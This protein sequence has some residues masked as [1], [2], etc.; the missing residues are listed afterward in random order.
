VSVVSSI[1]VTSNVT[2]D[3]SIMSVILEIDQ[4]TS[5]KRNFTMSLSS[6]PLYTYTYVTFE[7]GI[8]DVVVWAIDGNGNTA[9]LSGG[10][11]TVTPAPTNAGGGGGSQLPIIVIGNESVSNCNN[12]LKCEGS[13]GEDPFGCPSDCKINLN[14]LTCDDPA[15]QCITDLFDVRNKTVRFAIAGGLL[16]LFIIFIPKDS[17]L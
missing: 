13:N 16:A 5:G 3:N 1:I 10:F 7:T 6:A 11:F 12:N 14:Y 4:P 9:Q 8:H 2:D 17:E 15:Q